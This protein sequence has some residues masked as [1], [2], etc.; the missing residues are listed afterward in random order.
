MSITW[1]GTYHTNKDRYVPD[2]TSANGW[3][4]L[5]YDYGNFYASKTFFDPAKKWRIPWGWANEFDDAN[6]DVVFLFS[7]LDGAEQFNSSWANVQDLCG[8]KG[9]GV[10]G[11][12]GPFGL[13]TLAS[14]R[15]EEFTPVFFRIFKAEDPNK[16][17]VLMCSDARRIFKA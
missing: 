7:S 2:N 9:S 8:Q 14:K 11:I 4:G 6:V 12:V 5:R 3:S 17:K 13:L 1:S 10:P 16:Y 15:L